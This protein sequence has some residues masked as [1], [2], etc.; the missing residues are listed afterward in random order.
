MPAPES[1]ELAITPE[2]PAHSQADRSLRRPI[3]ELQKVRPEASVS[4]R[5]DLV[6]DR[7]QS[8]ESGRVAVCVAVSLGAREGDDIGST[9][10]HHQAM[11]AQRRQVEPPAFPG[12]P[13]RLL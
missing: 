10:E 2:F 9:T 8:P 3:R 1:N 12:R 11:V 7:P 4:V 13:N 5:F 6:H